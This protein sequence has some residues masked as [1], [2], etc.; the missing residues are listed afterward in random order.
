MQP[1]RLTLWGP[2]TTEGEDLLDQVTGALPGG[3]HFFEMALHP[4]A[5]RDIV[6][7]Q[8]TITQ[9]R[10]QNIIKVMRNPPCEGADR[11]HFLGLAELG[12]QARTFRDVTRHHEYGHLSP[13]LHRTGIDLCLKRLPSTR[14]IDHLAAAGA[15]PIWRRP[16][17]TDLHETVWRNNVAQVLPHE[18]RS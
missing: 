7:G 18:L 15:L 2:L 13:E 8:L 4:T 6:Q 1:D 10:S 16:L 17:L 9:D 12:L 14:D 5:M 3:Q 11:L